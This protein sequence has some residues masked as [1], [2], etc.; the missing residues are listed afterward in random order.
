MLMAAGRGTRLRPFTDL[1]PKPLLPLLGVPMAQFAVD[2]L[3]QAG[4]PR[5]VANIHHHAAAT[6]AGFAALDLA[7]TELVFS[8]ESA[9]LLG[10][11]GGIQKASP[12]LGEGPFF[13]MN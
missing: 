9:E 6:R 13:L 11:A 3:A 7:G 8:D 1:A 4:V 5:I 2:A 10:S 12:L